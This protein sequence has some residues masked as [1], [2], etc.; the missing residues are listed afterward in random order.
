M[1]N[2]YHT[3]CVKCIVL[4]KSELFTLIPSSPPFVLYPVGLYQVLVPT[5][6]AP[7]TSPVSVSVL[8]TNISIPNV[9]NKSDSM[10][11]SMSICKNK[12]WVTKWEFQF[13]MHCIFIQ[14]YKNTKI[15]IRLFIHYSKLLRK[16]IQPFKSREL[17]YW[18][19]AFV[20]TLIIHSVSKTTTLAWSL[21][22][23]LL[24]IHLAQL[25]HVFIIHC[26]R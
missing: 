9:N 11:S 24:D 4:L 15:N 22:Q 14:I 2:A 7:K 1:K 21:I 19:S 10:L 5:Y 26:Y 6:I 8:L 13:I 20:I 17:L 3:K 18:Y 12:I 16:Q 23:P 25:C